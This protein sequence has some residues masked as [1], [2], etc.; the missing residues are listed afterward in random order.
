[1][2]GSSCLPGATPVCMLQPLER[3]PSMQALTWLLSVV[4]L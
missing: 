4:L 1:M 2:L 3:R